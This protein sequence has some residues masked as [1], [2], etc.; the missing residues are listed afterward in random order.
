M[1][2]LTHYYRDRHIEGLPPIITPPVEDESDSSEELD[3]ELVEMLPDLEAREWERRDTSN[4]W[5]W[6]WI[7]LSV[8]SIL[9]IPLAIGLANRNG[10]SG[11]F[12][13]AII[14]AAVVWTM[15]LTCCIVY[16]IKV[17]R[18]D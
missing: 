8:V 2:L 12:L 4:C 1:L 13:G 16:S 9:I 18:L 5:C 10:E 3:E 6:S 14:T 11:F 15:L 7:C 17:S